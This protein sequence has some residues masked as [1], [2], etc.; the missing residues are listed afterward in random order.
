MSVRNG[1]FMIYAII[2]CIGYDYDTLYFLRK[3]QVN[4]NPL[5][6]LR[7]KGFIFVS[8]DNVFFF[9]VGR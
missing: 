4:I 5:F 3:N 7:I 6:Q 1:E 2:N 9:M 8:L